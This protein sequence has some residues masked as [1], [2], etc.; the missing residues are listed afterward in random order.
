MDMACSRSLRRQAVPTAPPRAK[1]SGG[2]LGWAL[3]AIVVDHLTV[4]RVAAGLGC[5][6]IPRT[7]PSSLR[8]GGG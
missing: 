3:T 8:A 6:G 2:G 5:R 4:T 7:A 1:I